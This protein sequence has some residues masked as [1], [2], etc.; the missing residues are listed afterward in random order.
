VN[1]GIRGEGREGLLH[2]PGVADIGLQEAV[3]RLAGNGA[4]RIEISGIGQFVDVQDRMIPTTDQ[5]ANQC[6][7]DETGAACNEDVHGIWK[8]EA[9][10]GR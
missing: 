1:D 8:S 6:G 5:M 2:G 3:V 4:Q 7:T 10:T 9:G